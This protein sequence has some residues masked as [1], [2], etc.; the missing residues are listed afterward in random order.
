MLAHLSGAALL[1]DL[2]NGLL[3]DGAAKRYIRCVGRAALDRERA[4]QSP[5]R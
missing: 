1:T 4:G 3:T 5:N 2:A